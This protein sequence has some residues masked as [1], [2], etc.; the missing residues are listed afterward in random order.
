[1]KQKISHSHTLFAIADRIAFIFMYT[2]TVA[3]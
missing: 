3:S 1:M 2:I